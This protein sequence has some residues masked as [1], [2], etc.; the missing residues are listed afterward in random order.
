[1]DNP[2]HWSFTLYNLENLAGHFTR[3][4][5]QLPEADAILRALDLRLVLQRLDRNQLNSEKRY[6]ALPTR[7]LQKG[8]YYACG[9]SFVCGPLPTSVVMP[10]PSDWLCDHVDLERAL[11]SLPA[12]TLKIVLLR[13]Q[14]LTLCEVGVA[15][16][17]SRTRVHELEQGAYKH[18]AERLRVA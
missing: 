9:V 18:L 16:D 7:M 3:E 15:L 10:D 12:R 11:A 13:Q 8:A 4:N 17:L 2:N 5:P 6:H 1:M 14:G